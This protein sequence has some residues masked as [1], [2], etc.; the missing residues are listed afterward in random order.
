MIMEPPLYYK[1]LRP[2]MRVVKGGRSLVSGSFLLA[3][4]RSGLYLQ[5]SPSY[6]FYTP[7]SGLIFAD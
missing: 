7:I 2:W 4:V 3:Q 5:L 6:N 1:D